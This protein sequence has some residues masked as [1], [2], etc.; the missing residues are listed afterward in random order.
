MGP[1]Y[2][3]WELCCSRAFAKD[4]F[5]VLE[6]FMDQFHLAQNIAEQ[7]EGDPTLFVLSKVSKMWR[8]ATEGLLYSANVSL[9]VMIRIVIWL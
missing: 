6:Y 7:L 8:K 2:C 3:L 4:S 5:N 9:D 1:H